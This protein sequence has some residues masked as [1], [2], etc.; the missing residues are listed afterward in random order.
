VFYAEPSP[1]ATHTSTKNKPQH[2]S[3]NGQTKSHSFCGISRH[4]LP[5]FA[6]LNASNGR[7]NH[8]SRIKCPTPDGP[9]NEE[10]PISQGYKCYTI[11]NQ[12]QKAPGYDLITGKILK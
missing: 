10:N 3:K 4:G 9:S 11:Q 8:P 7:R 6:I 1:S 2:L 5:I 12:S